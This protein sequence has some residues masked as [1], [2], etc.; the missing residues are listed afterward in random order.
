MR[1]RLCLLIAPAIVL[2]ACGGGSPKATPDTRVG[3]DITIDVPAAPGSAE[4]VKLA[5]VERGSGT[6]GVVLAHMLGSSQSAWSPIVGDLVDEG[7]HVLTFDFRGHGLSGGT[8]D[9]SHAALDLAAAVAKIRTLGASR[10]LVVGASLGGTAAIAVAATAD[11][12]GVVTLS[13]PATIDSLDAG[14]A[15]SRVTEPCLFIVGA[16][17]DSRYVEAAR[18]FEADAK[19]QKELQVLAGTSAHGTDLLTDSKVG[20]RARALVVNFLIDH[21][22]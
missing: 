14:A 18:A 13:A 2:A 3:T 12:D 4:V 17:D 19:G 7:F 8:R 16:N 15:A 9:P 6:V 1:T 20:K 5:A 11:L 22:G 21:R 10:V